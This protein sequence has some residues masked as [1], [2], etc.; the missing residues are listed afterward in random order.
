MLWTAFY[1]FDDF[2]LLDREGTLVAR[3]VDCRFRAAPLQRRAHKDPAAWRIVA[4][5]A[6]TCTVAA[7]NRPHGC[8]PPR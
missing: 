5:W 3:M 7:R 4:R 6:S 2:D 1:W 8:E